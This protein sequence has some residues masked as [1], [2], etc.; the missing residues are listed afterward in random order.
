[1]CDV[2]K[3]HTYGKEKLRVSSNFNELCLILMREL[4]FISTQRPSSSIAR[5]NTPLLLNNVYIHGCVSYLFK[6]EPPG[7]TR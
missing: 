5:Q 6:R 2:D 7:I 4:S 3:L 1:M